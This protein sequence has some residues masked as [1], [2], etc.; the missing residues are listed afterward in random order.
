METSYAD[1]LQQFAEKSG[2]RLVTRAAWKRAP[3][4]TPSRVPARKG[5]W[6][7][8]AFSAACQERSAGFSM[9]LAPRGGAKIFMLKTGSGNIV[10]PTCLSQGIN[11]C[12]LIP[13]IKAA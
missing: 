3:V 6:F 10:Y 11:T 13:N 7:Y 2:N 5:G 1:S 12:V 4:F 9:K 8:T